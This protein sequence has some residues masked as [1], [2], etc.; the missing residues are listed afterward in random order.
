MLALCQPWLLSVKSGAGRAPAQDHPQHHCRTGRV[1]SVPGIQ[2]V[3]PAEPRETGE[4]SVE[5]D[6]F[7]AALDR[8]GGVKAKDRTEARQ[9]PQTLEIQRSQPLCSSCPSVQDWR[10][11]V[12]TVWMARIQSRCP[13]R[14]LWSMPHAVHSGG[15]EIAIHMGPQSC[16]V[17]FRENY[18]DDHG[19]PSQP[20]PVAQAASGEEISNHYESWTDRRVPCLPGTQGSDHRNDGDSGESTGHEGDHGLRVGSGLRQGHLLME[21]VSSMACSRSAELSC[22]NCSN[23]FLRS[24]RLNER[25]R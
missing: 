1:V 18:S 19:S 6:P 15:L 11:D 14:W 2:R 4:T 10:H 22:A 13:A 20:S 7:A 12:L 9:G 8:E 5:R 16:Y 24:R 23:R 21:S 3:P 17:A 25:G